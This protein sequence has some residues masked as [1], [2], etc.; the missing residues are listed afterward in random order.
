MY[1]YDRRTPLI[2]MAMEHDSPEALRKYLHDHPDADKSKHTVKKDDEKSRVV[3]KYIEGLK[4]KKRKEDDKERQEKGKPKS[5]VDKY[6]DD[7]RAKKKKVDQE[8]R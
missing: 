6:I 2:V 3:N 8:S 7:L 1:D 4:D 5:D